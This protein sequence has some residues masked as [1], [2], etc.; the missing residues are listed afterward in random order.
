[1]CSNKYFL[2]HTIAFSTEKG[3]F[4]TARGTPLCLISGTGTERT[5]NEWDGVTRILVSLIACLLAYSSR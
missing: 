1:M 4:M 3:Q 5:R 2:M